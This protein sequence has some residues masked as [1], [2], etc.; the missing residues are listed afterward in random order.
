MTAVS[1]SEAAGDWLER[2]ELA[3][4]VLLV[5]A[6]RAAERA[7][8]LRAELPGVGLYYAY[9][10]FGHG[11][12]VRALDPWLAG[13]TVASAQECRELVTA[14]IEPG[15]LLFANPVKIPDH[16]AYAER[17]GVLGY[18]FQ[19][20]D[21]VDKLAR[22]APGAQ[23][24]CRV[25]VPDDLN[26]DGQRMSAKFGADPAAVPELVAY[27]QAVG[28][29]P[30]GLTFHVG[31][32]SSVPKLWTEAIRI[33]STLIDDLRSA[34]IP[35]TTLD[36]GGGLPVDYAEAGDAALESVTAEIRAALDDHL[37]AGVDAIA[38][39]GRALVA[40]S[41]VILTNVI[42]RETRD[43]EEW[44]YLDTGVFQSLLETLEFG[45]LLQRI[46]PI[47]PTTEPLTR[48]TVAGPTCD[49]DDVLSHDVRLPAGTRTGDRL[50]ITGAGAYTLAYASDFNG[51]PRPTVIDLETHKAV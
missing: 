37:P 14:G 42:G 44:L 39:P 34:G 46:E 2:N 6:D 47:A 35:L 15:R 12:V 17:L 27:A 28:L 26:V 33:C 18:A 21:E 32:Q 49:G 3:G 51:I 24:Q 4:P 11:S 38:E 50:M 41:A 36:L 10:C 25:R 13:Y 16:I 43:D 29:Q 1:W 20:R 30:F 22:L 31:S 23:V 7:R 40:D 48:F 8:K 45:R 19:S 9:K 5:D